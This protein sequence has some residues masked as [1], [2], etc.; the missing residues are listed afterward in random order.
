MAIV[1]GPDAQ[2]VLRASSVVPDSSCD[3]ST[4]LSGIEP[5]TCADGTYSTRNGAIGV[6][7][8]FASCVTASA[9]AGGTPATLASILCE[10]EGDSYN[11]PKY[12]DGFTLAP[13]MVR[14]YSP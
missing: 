5:L 4:P 12:G 11:D 7:S 14:Y 8:Q 10:C 13:Y 2:L 6:C 9:V 3:G 1:G